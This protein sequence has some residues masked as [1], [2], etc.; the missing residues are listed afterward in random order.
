MMPKLYRYIMATELAVHPNTTQILVSNNFALF[1]DPRYVMELKDVKN[2]HQS[3]NIDTKVLVQK[4]MP[5]L[6]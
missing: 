4:M 6:Y 1:F 5:N 2:F 3:K